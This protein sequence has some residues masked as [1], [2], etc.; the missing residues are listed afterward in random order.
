MCFCN[1]NSCKFFFRTCDAATIVDDGQLMEWYLTAVSF[2]EMKY[3]ER[4]MYYPWGYV[5]APSILDI[6]K[7]YM[8]H[9]AVKIGLKYDEFKEKKEYEE[10]V[11]SLTK[12]AENGSGKAQFLLGLMYEIG[13]G[14]VQDLEEAINWYQ[15]ATTNGFERASNR[16][17]VCIRRLAELKSFD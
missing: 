13:V 6:A 15:K 1:I 2:E 7:W 11:A 17:S 14:M 8:I 9:T 12:A 3:D 10:V 4:L 16:A 5:V